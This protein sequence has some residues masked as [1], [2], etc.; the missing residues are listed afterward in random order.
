MRIRSFCWIRA[1]SLR[2]ARMRNWWHAVAVTLT[3]SEISSSLENNFAE[4][5][6]I[7]GNGSTS[8]RRRIG[9]SATVRE[10]AAPSC[11]PSYEGL[12]AGRES[13]LDTGGG[14]PADRRAYGNGRG[15][16][17]KH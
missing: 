1:K 13:S 9:R 10:G 2:W 4:E 12:T 6:K 3:W 8:E 14:D 7:H 17:S 11:A 15:G 5:A 16:G